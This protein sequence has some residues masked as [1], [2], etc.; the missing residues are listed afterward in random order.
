MGK[1]SGARWILF[2]VGLLVA[3]AAFVAVLIVKAT[4]DPSHH[5]EANYYQRALAWDQTMEQQREN[6]RLGWQ[7]LAALSPSA[8]RRL[9]LQLT[10]RDRS[11]KAIDGAQVDAEIF[12]QA[13]GNQRFRARLSPRGDGH[14]VA[15]L[16]Y[17]RVGLW[18]L[19]IVV[20]RGKQRFTAQLKRELVAG[21]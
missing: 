9:E 11:G 5:V 4:G 12:H 6:R 14:Y 20:E 7:L 2:V 8:N 10:L 21:S 13:R 18:S 16:G 1:K 3:Q 19:Q 15:R 17:G